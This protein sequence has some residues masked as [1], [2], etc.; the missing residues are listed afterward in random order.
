[1]T[2]NKKTGKMVRP[3]TLGQKI[4]AKVTRTTNRLKSNKLKTVR[5][6]K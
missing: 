3:K 1:M 5:K 4:K 2:V 6:K